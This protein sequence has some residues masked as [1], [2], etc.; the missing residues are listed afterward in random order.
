MPKFAAI[1]NIQTMKLKSILIAL[2]IPALA[3]LAACGGGT[4]A[5][6]PKPTITFQT[7]SGFTFSDANA[8]FD[9][10]LNI[11]IRAASTDKKLAKVKVTVSA[12][13]AAA[14]TVWDTTISV[15]T[16]NYD[17]KYTVKGGT[18]DIQTLEV[19]AIDDN[20]TSAAVS[21]KVTIT[22][23]TYTVNQ[24]GNQ[25]VWNI[26]GLNKG[27]YDLNLQMERGSAEDEKLKDLKDM[28]TVSNPDFSKAWTSGNGSKFVRVTLND[29]NNVSSSADLL[30]LWQSK[31]ASATATITNLAV[32][33]YI[34]VKSGQAVGFNIYVIR[35]D[36]VSDVAGN[37]DYVKFTFIY[38]DI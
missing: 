28:T 1:K 20:G 29:W 15:A 9:S 17:Y 25:R 2:S 31:G 22:P 10:V 4:D 36:E 19:T 16:F 6:K 3:F 7:G 13:G 14:G 38:A 21:L 35:V 32:N 23:P 26:I 12:N 8:K 30:D 33:D 5:A 11:G 18:G 37:N 27:A 34:L 24:T